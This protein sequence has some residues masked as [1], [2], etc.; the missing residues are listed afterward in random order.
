[1]GNEKLVK[2]GIDIIENGFHKGDW[3]FGIN[4]CHTYDET[5]LLICVFKRAITIGRFFKEI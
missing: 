4:F 3:S 5:Y 2:F 1:M